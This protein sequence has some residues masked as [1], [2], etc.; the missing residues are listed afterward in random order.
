MPKSRKRKEPI[1]QTTTPSI[2]STDAQSCRNTIR[3]FHVL[4]KRRTQ[5]ENKVEFSAEHAK[6]LADIGEKISFLGGL[7]KYQHMSALGQ[8]D[9]RGGG[10]EKIFIGWMKE[11]DV[12]RRPEG[13]GKLRYVVNFIW[14]SSVSSYIQFQDA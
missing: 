2:P 6:E 3:Q 1:V 8:Q 7:E 5:L 14:S 12:H 10:S 13:R 9:E 11:L 4:L